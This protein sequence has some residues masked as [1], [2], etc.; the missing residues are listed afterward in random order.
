MVVLLDKKA[1]LKSGVHPLALLG[2][3]VLFSQVWNACDPIQEFFHRKGDLNL[4][5]LIEPAVVVA[6]DNQVTISRTDPSA[7]NVGCQQDLAYQVKFT[8]EANSTVIKVK[9]IVA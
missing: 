5:G 9:Q 8:A 1:P 3:S 4:T 7:V 6:L 2:T